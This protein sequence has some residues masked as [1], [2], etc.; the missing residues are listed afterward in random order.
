MSA[1]FR[2]AKFQLPLGIKI[3]KVVET[4]TKIPQ[5]INKTLNN[6]R[7]KITA[8]DSNKI[9]QRI[10]KEGLRIEKTI[11]ED[12]SDINDEEYKPKKIKKKK[13]V[14]QEHKTVKI[15]STIFVCVLC[16]Q[17]FPS[18]DELE[19]HMKSSASCQRTP[20]ACSI[21][22]KTFVNRS[23]CKAH[24]A[25]AHGEKPK[26]PCNKCEKSFSNSIALQAHLE[27]LHTEYFD[28][29]KDGFSCKM[30]EETTQTKPLILHHINTKH[31]HIT[32]LLCDMC[33]KS[34][35]NESGLRAHLLTHND[36]KPFMCQICSKSFKLLSTLKAHIKTHSEEKRY[37]C[38]ECGKT[39]KKNCTLLEHKKHHAGEFSFECNICS[40]KFVSKS[41]CNSHI[42]T[43]MIQ[44]T[45]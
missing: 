4:T 10:A 30:C 13:T 32:T 14:K 38:D 33:G 22:G 39:F 19:S 42:K 26:F 17:K 2:L 41:A 36:D 1:F 20:I 29:T 12:E 31:L 34:F 16:Y 7:L 27:T 11:V 9:V 5:N 8:L 15:R 21:C 24:V 43:H 40:K 45:S 6:S 25:N 3:K 18:F 37:V 35:M 28:A 23:R 44:T